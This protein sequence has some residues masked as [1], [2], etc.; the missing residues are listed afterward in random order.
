MAVEQIK[1]PFKFEFNK[2]RFICIYIQ[3]LNKGSSV[4]YMI[5][6]LNALKRFFAIEIFL[7]E[8]LPCFKNDGISVSAKNMYSSDTR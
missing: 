6:S 1:F 8:C 7:F 4:E 3:Q 2:V 5:F